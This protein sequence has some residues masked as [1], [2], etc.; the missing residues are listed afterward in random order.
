MHVGI[1]TY[2]GGHFYLIELSYNLIHIMEEV[3][4]FSLPR[5]TGLLEVALPRVWLGKWLEPPPVTPASNPGRSIQVAMDHPIGSPKIEELA[6]PGQKVAVIVDDATRHTPVNLVLPFLLERLNSAG[7]PD[8]DICLVIALGTHLPMS[9]AEIVA[10][11]GAKMFE[12]LQVEQ[13]ASGADRE[14]IYL[15]QSVNGI[16]TW[17]HRTI[18]E[19]DLRIG[20]GMITPHMDAGF[21]GGAKI[22]LPGVCGKA[23]VDEFHARAVDGPD[24][25]LGNSEAP[26]RLE[27]EAFVQEQIPLHFLVNL[28]LTMDGEIFQVVA[29]DAITAHRKG[30]FFARQVYGATTDRRYAV[31]LANCAP[32]QQDLWQSFKGMWSGD[33]ITAEGGTLIWVTQAPGGHQHYPHLLE[34]LGNDPDSLMFRLDRGELDDPAS[35]ATGILVGMKKKRMHISMVSQGISS[36]EAAIMGVDWYPTVELAVAD[37]AQRL[38]LQNTPG[39][40]AVL[41]YAGVTLPLIKEA[42]ILNL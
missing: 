2:T 36:D 17:V 18:V 13:S 15:G 39:F 14:M 10:R 38:S 7:V 12:R 16:P 24:N 25:P 9:K 34:Y 5:E 11:I 19:A 40:L 37:A 20:L 3:V 35:A 27:L 1:A 21:S 33:L 31:V 41:P 29:G 30:V 26:L 8:R 28:I 4:E 32:Y 42:P 22:I 23:T 6:R